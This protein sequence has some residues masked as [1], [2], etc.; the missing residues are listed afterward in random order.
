MTILRSFLFYIGYI[1]SGVIASLLACLIGP[2]IN[3]EKRLKFFSL[4]PKFANWFLHLTCKIE[5]EIIG[6]HYIPDEPCVIVSNHQGQWETFSMQYLF[7]PLCTLLKKELLYIPLWGWAMAML[8]PIAINRKKPKEALSQTLDEGSERLKSGMYV[9][10]FPEGTRVEAGKVGRY[11]RSCFELAK[12]NNVKVL[13]LCHN[14]GECWPAH[15]F[16][17][18][19]G[20]IK[21]HVGEPFLVE[22]TKQSALKTENWVKTKLNLN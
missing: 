4:W 15:K 9:L 10:L 22:D 11:A 21:L 13:P 18:K 20:K 14:S 17:K 1:C 2:F 7:H 19:P 5:V 8:K 3:L 16:I 12:R 6:E